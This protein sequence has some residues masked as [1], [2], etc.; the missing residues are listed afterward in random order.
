MTS[1][2]I[3]EAHWGPPPHHMFTEFYVLVDAAG[4]PRTI[5]SPH[6]VNAYRRPRAMPGYRCIK[7]GVEGSDEPIFY[8]GLVK[9]FG[10]GQ[11][12]FP[13]I[14][15]GD[16]AYYYNAIF[17]TPE[18]AA[19]R[20]YSFDK[21][22]LVPMG[23]IGTVNDLTSKAGTEIIL[24][25]WLYFTLARLPGNVN[26]EGR[27]IK[28]LLAQNKLTPAALEYNVLKYL[29]KYVERGEGPTRRELDSYS[30]SAWQAWA[31]AMIQG[32]AWYDHVASRSRVHGPWGRNI[33]L[34]GIKP[35]PNPVP[36][37]AD[38][39]NLLRS[40][41]HILYH[42]PEYVRRQGLAYCQGEYYKF[43]QKLD[44]LRGQQY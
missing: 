27:R 19:K 28:Y 44:G 13:L 1:K 41:G 40:A 10:P 12:L 5:R 29:Q 38:F 14:D 42:S 30:A 3:I 33:S 16:S 34:K 43:S 25:Q 8:A 32:V 23:T 22:T 2:E 21:K 4:K 36:W 37:P 31:R 24:P 18:F 6:V 15:W 39:V 17:L 7:I 35:D 26:A 11:E 9:P 20:G